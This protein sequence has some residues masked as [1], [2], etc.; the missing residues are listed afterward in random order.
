MTSKHEVTEEQ[1][2]ELMR[3]ATDAVA[4]AAAVIPDAGPLGPFIV[5]AAM[6]IGFEGSA[7]RAVVASTFQGVLEQSRKLFKSGTPD[8]ES[9][10]GLN[11]RQAVMTR[12]QH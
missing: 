11:E 5:A 4:R 2:D 10:G 12:E 8:A 6:V 7:S 1:R 9:P 3:I